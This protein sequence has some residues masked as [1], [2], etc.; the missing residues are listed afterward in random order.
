MTRPT[1][2]LTAGARLQRQLQVIEC[3]YPRAWEQIDS[4]RRQ[5]LTA[6]LWPAWCFVPLARVR[7]LICPEEA[8][9]D[10]TRVVDAAIVTGLAAWRTTRI[11]WPSDQTGPIGNGPLELDGPPDQLP[12]LLGRPVWFDLPP[13]SIG[14]AATGATRGMLV[15]LTYD[16]RTRQ[17]ELRLLLEP[18]RRWTLGSVPLVPLALPLTEPTLVRCLDASI[19]EHVRRHDR[20]ARCAVAGELAVSLHALLRLAI[21]LTVQLLDPTRSRPAAASG[22]APASPESTPVDLDQPA[23]AAHEPHSS[24]LARRFA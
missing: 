24:P 9:Q 14:S 2:G 7:D 3:R 1:P 17:S 20:L 12:P 19:R 21:G 16:E 6:G 11:V 4:L 22:P 15:H 8:A 5:H 23:L 10:P 13:G 18:T